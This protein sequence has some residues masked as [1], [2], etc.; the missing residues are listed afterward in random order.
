ML[1]SLARK[2]PGTQYGVQERKPMPGLPS[3]TATLYYQDLYRPSPLPEVIRI[4]VDR[5]AWV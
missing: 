3:I 1:Q 2:L 5:S 4:R